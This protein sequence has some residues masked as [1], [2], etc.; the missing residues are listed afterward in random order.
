LDIPIDSFSQQI[1]KCYCKYREIILYCAVVTE[2]IRTDFSDGN[3]TRL[4]PR[5]TLEKVAGEK[6]QLEIRLCFALFIFHIYIA[7]YTE[8]LTH[9]RAVRHCDLL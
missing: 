5:F 9:Y 7:K 1:L 8:R 3:N 2:K 4:T 6:F